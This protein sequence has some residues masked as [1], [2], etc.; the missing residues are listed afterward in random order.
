MGGE[1][2]SSS[3]SSGS[4]SNWKEE[5]LK[6]TSQNSSQP[7]ASS[8]PD[9]FPSAGSSAPVSGA[10]VQEPNKN[11]SQNV[12]QSVSSPSPKLNFASPD[13]KPKR[14]I[15]RIVIPL[16]VIIIGVIVLFLMLSGSFSFKAPLMENPFVSESFSQQQAVEKFSSSRAAISSQK[17]VEVAS[18]LGFSQNR[19]AEIGLDDVSF[20]ESKL[21][22]INGSGDSEKRFGL[23]MAQEASVIAF[24]I[25]LISNSK[26]LLDNNFDSSVPVGDLLSS[27]DSNTV[28]MDFINAELEK[29]KSFSI[30][31]AN[32]PSASKEMDGLS[33]G[34]VN[35]A[36][37][38]MA[39]YLD[40]YV[41]YKAT[42][43]RVALDA[44]KIFDA[45]FKANQLNVL[46]TAYR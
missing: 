5:Y 30:N 21:S 17:T 45:Y 18:A 36:I 20:F 33:T 13:Q 23:V 3:A 25:A 41:D 34:F 24:S 19:T 29:S 46:Q 4:S 39:A 1:Q 38:Y 35:R 16:I 26:Y 14:S 10:Q 6:S 40:E 27:L 9:P 37:P 44:N 8:Q 43:V 7:G 32:I 2:D 28:V 15:V 12:G 22:S 31:P 11:E 42:E